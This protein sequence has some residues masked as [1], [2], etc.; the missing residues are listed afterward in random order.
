M[1]RYCFLLHV[2]AE[3][4]D[5]YRARHAKVWPEMLRALRETGWRN[6][7]IFARPDGLLVGYVEADDLDAARQAMSQ[8]EVNARWQA[9]MGKYFVDLPGRVDESIVA[10][11]EIF[12]LDEQLAQL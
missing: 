2:R 12:N 7:S 11:E 10:L 1:A 3:L 8:T 6:Y 4:L 9:D 5:E